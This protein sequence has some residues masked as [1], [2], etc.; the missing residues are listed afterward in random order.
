MGQTYPVAAPQAAW[1]RVETGTPMTNPTPTDATAA[2]LA[3]GNPYEPNTW[4]EKAKNHPGSSTYNTAGWENIPAAPADPDFVNVV[5]VS[6][7]HNM[8]Y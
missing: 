2:T 1:Q 5:L 6:K 4:A 7:S 8:P 3:S